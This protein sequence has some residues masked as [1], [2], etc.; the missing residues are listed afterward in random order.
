MKKIKLNKEDLNTMIRESI[1]EVVV[2]N[3]EQIKIDDDFEELL[4]SF[5]STGESY[6]R[7]GEHLIEDIIPELKELYIES[8][9]AVKRV[10]GNG[11]NLNNLSSWNSGDEY[12]IEIP[13]NSFDGYKAYLE[14]ESYHFNS[15]LQ[16]FT[17]DIT[18]FEEDLT[19]ENYEK[20]KQAFFNNKEWLESSIDE[21]L[22]FVEDDIKCRYSTVNISY[23]ITRHSVWIEINFPYDIE[24]Y[25]R[26]IN[27]EED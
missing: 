19:S 2:N 7:V 23:S 25:D 27:G 4:I 1:E 13:I 5:S 17:R 14:N 12:T 26:F 6:K 9:N 8:I 3:N 22:D 24:K 10:F 21:E 18:D 11:I 20:M 15:T 16:E